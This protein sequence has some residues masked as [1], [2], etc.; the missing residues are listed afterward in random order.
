MDTALF[1]ELIQRYRGDEEVME[2]LK[3]VVHL[4]D[5]GMPVSTLGLFVAID[6]MCT[7]E[8]DYGPADTYRDIMDRRATIPDNLS[9]VLES[10]HD[11]AIR[12]IRNCFPLRVEQVTVNDLWDALGFPQFKTE[13]AIAA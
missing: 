3:T 8:F 7:D 2:I 1:K 10:A 13:P 9:E 6:M 12:R 5:N 4:S 11:I